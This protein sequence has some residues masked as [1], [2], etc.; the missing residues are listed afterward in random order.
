MLI[1]FWSKSFILVT[2]Q[3]FCLLLSACGS[4][5][6]G[7]GSASDPAP[8]FSAAN[9]SHGIALRRRRKNGRLARLA[10]LGSGTGTAPGA[11]YTGSL[12]LGT[13]LDQVTVQ[14][15]GAQVK[16]TVYPKAHLAAG[17]DSG[18]V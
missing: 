5:G 15:V 8:G 18:S 11:I 17:D 9:R 2:A 12:D 10:V 6:G 7:S 4:E 3:V 14:V 1:F 16:F 13:W